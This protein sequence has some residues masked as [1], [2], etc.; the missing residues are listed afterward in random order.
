MEHF[1]IGLG[2]CKLLCEKHGGFLEIKN[3]ETGGACVTAILN[4]S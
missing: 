2:V 4:I 3:N 1:G